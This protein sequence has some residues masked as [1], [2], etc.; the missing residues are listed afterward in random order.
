MNT[1]TGWP[2]AV[3]FDLDGTLIDSAP[4]IAASV[5]ILLA[6]HGLGPLS[7]PSVT[8]M[9]G[10]GIEKTVERAFAAVGRP[11]TREALAAR[12][13]EMV[14]IYADNLTRLTVLTAGAREAVE[15][16]HT[17]GIRLGVATNKPQRATE[18]VL[19]HFGFLPFLDSIIGGDAGVQKKPAP[20]IPL[21]SLERLGVE[22]WDAVMVG[23]SGA[24]VDSAKAAGIAA[25]AVRGGYSNAP[26]E[27]L[28]ANVVIDSLT[29]LQDALDSIRRER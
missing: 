28:G 3:L 18:I 27:S 12:N 26:I 19:G 14:D 16:L 8:A 1:R 24:D 7:V 13:A 4:D 10:H 5:N 29:S 20:D 6:R 23:D 15:T 9:V 11:L 17:E 21:A 25:I 22:P 2:R